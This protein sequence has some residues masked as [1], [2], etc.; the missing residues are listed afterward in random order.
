MATPF[1]LLALSLYFL[2]LASFSVCGELLYEEGYTV[3]TILDGNKREINPHSVL[4]SY[5][6]S[7]DLIVLDS[8]GSAFHTLSFRDSREGVIKKY[9]GNGSAGFSD[10]E[11]DSAMFNKPKSF[12]VDLKGNLYVADKNNNVIRKVSKS[13]V[14]TIAGGYS[15]KPGNADGPGRNASFSDDFELNFIPGS[16]ALII[17]DHGNKLIRQINLKAEDCLQ[18]SPAVLGITSAWLLTLALGVAC[19]FG[20]FAGVFIQPYVAAY[21]GSSKLLYSETWKLFLINLGRRVVILCFDTRSAIASS[22]MCAFLRRLIGLSMS[23][24]TL[25]ISLKKVNPKK[26]SPN[27]VSFIDNDSSCTTITKSQ[28]YADQLQDL[29]SFGGGVESSDTS[30]KL[31]DQTNGTEQLGGSLCNNLGKIEKM[32]QCNL[33]SF[34]EPMEAVTLPLLTGN[35]TC[36]VRRNQSKGDKLL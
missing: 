25:M 18:D 9:C 23:Y 17:S 1:P 30:A 4:P 13:G 20:L 6:T 32:I 35:S 2:T 31:L 7:S 24:V 27:H 11:L 10:G 34:S 5:T 29:V 8:S 15:Q 16:C 28:M 19:L 26:H 22:T 3:T 36:A 12:A 33:I 14:T 21:G